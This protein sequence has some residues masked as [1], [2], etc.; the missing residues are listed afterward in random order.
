MKYPGQLVFDDNYA[1]LLIAV[2][3]PI[4]TI[5]FS[6]WIEIDFINKRITIE[7]LKLGDQRVLQSW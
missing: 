3:T 6:L 2:K 7:T 1:E 4:S 5:Y